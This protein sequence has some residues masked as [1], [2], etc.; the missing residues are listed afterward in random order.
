M[1]LPQ[2]NPLEA[3][4]LAGSYLLFEFIPRCPESWN[5]LFAPGNSG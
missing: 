5:F 1:K 2:V 4:E 3:Y